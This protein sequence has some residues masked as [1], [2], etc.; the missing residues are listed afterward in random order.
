MKNKKTIR[1]DGKIVGYYRQIGKGDYLV[2]LP[3]NTLI[4]RVCKEDCTPTEWTAY[5]CHNEDPDSLERMEYD[6]TLRGGLFY[7]LDSA[8]AL[9]AASYARRC[10]DHTCDQVA[11]GG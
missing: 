10:S 6:T 7:A 9:E 1:D 5:H 4:G 2:Y 3:D 8:D 11:Y